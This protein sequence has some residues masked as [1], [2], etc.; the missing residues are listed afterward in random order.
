M[1]WHFF[2]FKR[3]DGQLQQQHIYMHWL[4]L[5]L[6]SVGATVSLQQYRLACDTNDAGLLCTQLV[7]G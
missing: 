6:S 3:F 7:N 1:Q 5:F 4:P 2:S